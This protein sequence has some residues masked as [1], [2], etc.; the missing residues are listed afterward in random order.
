MPSLRNVLKAL[1]LTS[2]AAVAIAA[3]VPEEAGD[4]C[5]PPRPI[6]SHKATTTSLG[7]TSV[8]STPTSTP[9]LVTKPVGDTPTLPPSGDTPDLSGTNLTLQYV[10]IGRGIQNYT[11]TGAGSNSTAIGAIATLFDATDLA[12]SDEALLHTIPALIVNI[13]VAEASTVQTAT[14]RLDFDVLGHHFFDINGV[15]TFDLDTEDKILYA[16]KVMSVNAPTDASKG[17]AGT[18]AVPWLQLKAK[19]P[20]VDTSVGLGEVYRV[21]TAGGNA[22]PCT[23]AGVITVQYAAEYWFYA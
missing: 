9:T 15:A 23:E 11:C 5:A 10:A 2:L 1:A 22:T 7:A 14:Q 8:S 20:Y 3:P 17:P 16:A 18:G 21:E 6:W 13:P 4:A 19:V 12:Y